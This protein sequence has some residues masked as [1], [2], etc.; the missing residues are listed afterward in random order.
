MSTLERLTFP[1][2]TVT[3][4]SKPLDVY[5]DV[6]P[7]QSPSNVADAILTGPRV[8]A[9]IYFHGGGLTVGNRQSW[10]PT[11]LHKRATNAGYAFISADYQLLP[12]ATGHD[13]VQ[14]IGDLLAYVVSREFVAPVVGN[15]QHF[16]FEI[17]PEAVVVTGSSAGGLCAYIAAMHCVY[18]KPKA[19]VSMY[20]MGADFFSPHYLTPKTKPFFRGREILDPQDFPDF[21]HHNHL[22]DAPSFESLQPI[23]DSALAYHPQTYHIPGYPAN[24]RMLLTR[25]YL[26]LGVFID[27]Y[28]GVH[29]NGGISLPLRAALESKPA[30]G[31]NDAEY[32]A[33]VRSLVPP[34]H[35]SLFTQFNISA[36][37]P[38]TML[39]HGTEDSAVP[40]QESRS[41]KR[42]LEAAGV[43]VE[44]HEV[45]GR[46]HSFDYEEGAEDLFGKAVF[47]KVEEFLARHIGRKGA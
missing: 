4:S 36:D 34:E 35:H 41:L 18:P 26:Q 42:H 45:E 37:W 24:P 20:G 33:R 10:F 14:D 19:V 5:V 3:S 17:D 43:E 2:K 44:L 13:I 31:E 39:I 8:P 16:T 15:E 29:E 27:Y 47:D 30:F 40:V 7:P 32:I 25:L 22:P 46:E 9:V 12:P 6:Y 11:W 38:P 28:T 21:L 1:Y 23:A